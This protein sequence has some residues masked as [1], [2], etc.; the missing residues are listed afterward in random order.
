MRFSSTCLAAAVALAPCAVQANVC[1]T[2]VTSE[3]EASLG[4]PVAWPDEGQTVH[5]PA[6]LTVLGHPVSYVLVKRGGAGGR[7]DEI[8]Y[9]LQGLERKV[10]QP[11]DQ[12][13]LRDFDAEFDSADCADSKESSCGVVYRP[14]GGTFTGA[15]IGSGE[16]Y[17][18]RD[19]RGPSLA[20]IRTD[21]D[22]PDSDPVF[23]VCFYRGE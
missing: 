11:H 17:V 23:L 14:N 7:I 6:G 22:L 16:V 13:L 1:G 20:L 5:T 15:E 18:A 4:E 19:A 9:R 8:G 2:E 21:Y 12:R 3:L 10:G